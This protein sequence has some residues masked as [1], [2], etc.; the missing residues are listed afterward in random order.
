MNVALAP[1]G[2]LKTDH[3]Y[4][5]L[6]MPLGLLQAIDSCTLFLFVD[7]SPTT[8]K[9]GLVGVT[10]AIIA[11]AVRGGAPKASVSALSMA[12]TALRILSSSGSNRN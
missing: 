1:V 5:R 6:E 10:G 8:E 4:L 2:P 9:V 3:V 7:A 12:S 11:G